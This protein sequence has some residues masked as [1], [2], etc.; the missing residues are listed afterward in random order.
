M[1]ERETLLYWV[2]AQRIRLTPANESQEEVE[3][4]MDDLVAIAMHTESV[5]LA[6]RCADMLEQELMQCEFSA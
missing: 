3:E 5:A 1:L 2:S 6:N 4:A